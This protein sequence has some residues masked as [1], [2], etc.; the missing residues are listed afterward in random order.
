MTASLRKDRERRHAK[1]ALGARK[2]SAL[3]ALALI[4]L[5]VLGCYNSSTGEASIAGQ[6]KFKLP[7]FP[8]SGAHAVEVFT[9][10][11]Y[12]PSFRSQEIPRILPPPD[13]VPVN[14]KEIAYSTLTEYEKLAV[15]DRVV[16]AYNAAAAGAVYDV[17]CAV[18]HGSQL[19][20]DGPIVPFM[21]VG[22]FPAD[23]TADLTRGATDGELFAFISLGGRQGQ[24]ARVRGRESRS[25]MPQFGF[26][27]SQDDRWALVRFLRDRIGN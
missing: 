15:P 8:K 13:S 14:G 18:C 25:P 17:N 27:L 10:M 4:A 1:Q 3:M 7:A 23:L 5:V 12:Q 20:G 26:L 9:E 21:G 6:I 11:H 16:A 22:P 2:A 24:A 19:K